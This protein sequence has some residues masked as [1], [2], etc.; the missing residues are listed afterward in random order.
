[1]KLTE[2]TLK[3]TRIRHYQD[4]YVKEYGFEA[5]MV[6]ARQKLLIELLGRHKPEVVLEVGCGA[7]LLARRAA[8]AGLAIRRWVIV[9]PAEEFARAAAVGA[10]SSIEMR[11]VRGF[12]EDSVTSALTACGKPPDFVIVSSL[13]HELPDPVAFLQSIRTLLNANSVVHL[14][15]P[16]AGSFHRRLARAMGLIPAEKALTARNQALAQC[17]VFDLPELVALLAQ[18]GFT[19]EET[20][21]YL[22]KP[23]THKQLESIS[24]LMTPELLEGLWR[25]GRELPE[26]ASEIYVQ[27]KRRP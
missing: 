24:E 19:V 1:M 5:A 13:L 21:G 27:A 18:A 25:L 4:L 15:V 14:N 17:R 2:P 22:I 23:F 12:M 20:G 11:V 16:N 8:Q 10:P 6:A 7:D 26:W 3:Q 9:E